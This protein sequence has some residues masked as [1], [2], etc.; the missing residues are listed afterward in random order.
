[1]DE[2]GKWCPLCCLIGGYCGQSCAG[3]W[4]W[5]RESEPAPTSAPQAEPV[6]QVMEVTSA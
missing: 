4:G 1:M 6:E 5:Y 2:E 3:A